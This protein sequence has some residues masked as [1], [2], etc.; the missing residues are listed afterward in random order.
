MSLD[1]PSY[2]IIPIIF[3]AIT[4]CACCVKLAM[5][6]GAEKDP[7]LP[8]AA[9]KDPLLPTNHIAST[10]KGAVIAIKV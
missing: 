1:I 6:D 8:T 4:A 3:L 5:R 2:V 10:Y 9:E 7:L